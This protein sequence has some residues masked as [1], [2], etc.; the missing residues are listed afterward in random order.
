MFLVTFSLAEPFAETEIKSLSQN[1]KK[2]PRVDFVLFG[3]LPSFYGN[4]T[5]ENFYFSLNENSSNLSDVFNFYAEERMQIFSFNEYVTF[6][7]ALGFGAF[8]DYAEAKVN[9]LKVENHFSAN[10]SLGFEFYFHQNAS[11]QL[12][13]SHSS[14]YF[15]KSSYQT[16]SGK[17]VSHKEAA[18]LLLSQAE[19]AIYAKQ[20]KTWTVTTFTLVGICCAAITTDVI[21]TLNDNLPYRDTVQNISSI[22][23]GSSLLCA[24]LS[25]KIA[26]SRFDIAV[27]KYNLKLLGIN[28][29]Y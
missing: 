21:F 5:G 16:P 19:S 4:V 10:I 27:D 6:G 11:A 15:P 23:V 12:P 1:N 22:T 9:G 25:S 8:W 3:Y 29:T 7:M 18:A 26:S 20:Y 2:Y 24:L 28:K 14:E 13:L 17:S